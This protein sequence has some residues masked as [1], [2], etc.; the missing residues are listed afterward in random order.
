VQR[1]AIPFE[2]FTGRLEARQTVDVRPQVSGFLLK[3]G[4]KAGAEVKQGDVLFEIDSRP[5]QAGLDKAKAGLEV[6]LARLKHAEADVARV[7]AL[8]TK[9]GASREDLDQA[10]LAV[11]VAAAEVKRAQADLEA[12]QQLLSYT[13]VAAPISGQVGQPLVD[14]GNLVSAGDRGN[15]TVL[16]KLVSLDPIGL[17]FDMDERSFL[18]YQKVVREGQVKVEGGPLQVGLSSEKGF[19]HTGTIDSFGPALDPVTGTIRVRG[20]MPNPDRLLL[21]GLFVRVRVPFGKARKVLEVP[22]RAVGTDQSRH[23]VLVVNG[24]DIVERREV[25]LGPRDDGMRSVEEGIGP[26]D[27]V[28]THPGGPQPGDKVEPRRT[29]PSDRPPG[30]D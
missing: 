2:D 6:A 4:F 23:F 29:P 24:K 14:P 17:S 25:K 3:V 26:D 1:E 8:V 5:Y 28:V 9:G 16:V 11:T 10:M 22:E 12:A 30:K 20:E 15:G 13:K 19:P 18:R 27:W 7:K 21:P